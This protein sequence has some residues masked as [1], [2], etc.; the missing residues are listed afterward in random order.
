MIVN[1]NT[2]QPYNPDKQMPNTL[3]RFIWYF[4]R[5]GH[6]RNF[7]ITWVL[8][9]LGTFFMMS[10][11]YSVK[12]VMDISAG[13][14]PDVE[15]NIFEILQYPLGLFIAF[16]VLYL[17]FRRLEGWAFTYCRP[18]LRAQIR[19]D[20]FGYLQYH[21][22]GYFLGNFAGSLAHKVTEVSYKINDMLMIFSFHFLPV[23]A[24]LISAVYYLGVLHWGFVVL[25][26]VWMVIYCISSWYMAKGAREYSEAYAGARS[27]LMGQIV[28][29][30]TNV[31]NVR[32]FARYSYE[33]EHLQ[34]YLKDEIVSAQDVYRYMDGVRLIQGLFSVVLMVAML[35]LAVYLWKDISAG[36]FAMVLSLGLLLM[37]SSRGM[38]DNLLAIMEM[39]GAAA[40][41]IETIIR[42]HDIVDTKGAKALTV[43]EGAIS[44]DKVT[45]SHHNGTDVFENLSVDIK[46]GQKV[47]LVGASGAGKSTFVN[48]L[49]RFYDIQKGKIAIDGQDIAKVKQNSLREAVS[50]IPQEPMLF[51]RTL[52][53]NI[54][55][56]CVN[57]TDEEVMS[58]SKKAY[59]HDF[60]KDV[61][62]GYSAM[63]GERGVRLSGGQRQRIAVARAILKDAPILILDEATAA[64][65]SESEAVI[66]HAM[67]EVMKDKTVLVIAHRLST[68]AHMDRILVFDEGEIVEDG[69]HEELLKKNG[70]YAKLWK[71]QS[72]GFLK[73]TEEE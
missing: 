56:G 29:T 12:Q 62:E 66:Q 13:I 30:V 3:G 15:Q 47:G 53:D 60:I 73:S 14:P 50:V 59:A 70:R 36:D 52:L 55:Y 1:K 61:K 2:L 39:A 6:M 44:F 28:D 45:F 17:V 65:D 21:S 40:E 26:I 51:H 11:P 37:N 31:A 16:N 32:I 19:Q 10:I 25:L 18:P 72:G 69:S 33:H 46:P 4:M 22:H 43:K 64:L 8:G 57:A 23:I 9:T 49:V 63:V 5:N 7:I 42:P 20:L 67:Q 41:G 38:T 58:A 48:L 27:K 71:M 34:K 68:I 35:F 54:R 24:T